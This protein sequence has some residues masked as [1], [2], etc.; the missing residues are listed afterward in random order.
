PRHVAIAIADACEA[1]SQAIAALWEQ[2]WAARANGSREPDPSP[3]TLTPAQ[4]PPDVRGFT[5]RNAELDALEAVLAELDGGN[6]GGPVLITA[7]AGTA[8][9]GKTALAVHFGHRVAARFPD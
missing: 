4:L 8:G 1:D 2:T 3:G 6:G 9:V 5:G 7:V